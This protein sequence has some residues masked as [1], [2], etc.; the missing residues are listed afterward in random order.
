MRHLKMRI[1]IYTEDVS[2]NLHMPMRIRRLPRNIV[3]RLNQLIKIANNL[4]NMIFSRTSKK[5]TN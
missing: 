2:I 3:L 5:V 1:E 4:E